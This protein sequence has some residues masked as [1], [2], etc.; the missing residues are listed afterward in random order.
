MKLFARQVS[1]VLLLGLACSVGAA[2]GHMYTRVAPSGPD[3]TSTSSTW[4]NIP[5]LDLWFYQEDQGNA[6][7]GISAE[8]NATTGK[9]LFVRALID[10]V[11]ASPSDVVFCSESSSWCRMFQFS[12]NI[13]K[14]IHHVTFQAKVDGGGTAFFGD[15]SMW[16][17]TAPL[18]VNIVAPASGAVLTTTSSTWEDVPG[19]SVN[20]VMPAT[21]PLYLSFSG[22][23]LCDN[24]KRGR[25]RILVDGVAGSP[26]DVIV[27]NDLIAG[28]RGMTFTFPS[29]AAGSH[30]VKVQWSVDAGGTA[31]MGDRTLAVI[32]SDPSLLAAGRGGIISTSA[33]SGPDIVTTSASFTDVQNLGIDIHVPDNAVLAIQF[34]GETEVSGG[35]MFMRATIDGVPCSPSDV[36]LAYQA[37]FGGT[38]AAVFIQK[39][40]AGGT[41]HVALQWSVDPTQTGY[42]GD[43]NMTVVALPCAG[44]DMTSPIGGVTPVIGSFPILVLL[45]D[46]QRPAHP[47]PTLGSITNV[48]HGAAPSVADF[49]SVN[50]RN[51]FQISHAGIFG[52]FAADKP[53]SCYWAAE[54][55]SDADHDGFTSGHVRKWWEAIT[56]ADA[57]FDYSA[58]DANGDGVLDPKEL[59]IVVVIPQTGAFGSVR[60]PASQQYPTWQPMVVDGVRIPL[61]AEVYAGSPV[62]LGAFAHE[63]SHLLLNLPDLYFTFFQPYAAGQYSI[64]DVCY[65]D[66]HLDPLQ[67]IRLGWLQPTVIRRSGSHVI[68][69]IESDGEA[70]ILM[71][72]EHGDREYFIVENRKRHVAYDS[73]IADSGLAVWHIMEDP[74]VYGALP[75]PAGVS[76]SDW[77]TVPANDWGRRAIRMIRPV[78]G[79]P[80]NDAKALWDGADAATGYD[81]LS[82]DTQPGHAQLRWSD[83]TPSGFAMR[84]ISPAAE[85]MSVLFELPATATGTGGGSSVPSAFV[86][87]QNYP[88]PFNPVTTIRF[89]LPANSDVSLAVYSVLGQKVMTLIDRPLGAGHHSVRFDG[90][91]V[92]SGVYFYRLSTGVGVETKRMMLI[93]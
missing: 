41:R 55:P 29:V 11:P 72:P 85:N 86:L 18:L 79:P 50:S 91:G 16:V 24:G 60:A 49:F 92:A 76:A 40:V 36:G 84:Q 57:S 35:R 74:A 26:S 34:Q 12:A 67:K 32:A 75:A 71:D 51:T 25:L 22:E 6:C 87:E 63:L 80:F 43:R 3:W 46:P 54:D 83:G 68:S 20:I 73:Q 7:I 19:L 64:M 30:A 48:I 78:C 88:N 21:G 69:A 17:I 89:T 38:A 23:V 81:L 8:S 13:A 70:C 9:R 93:R 52:W 56:K 1:L 65:I 61:I 53:D 2:Q 5:A 37:G 66:S 45:W 77:A 31:Y 47:A 39:G 42:L 15:R 44:P 27:A 4:V 59:G 58:Y 14:G 33:P 10:G 28:V 62:N 82:T 90:T